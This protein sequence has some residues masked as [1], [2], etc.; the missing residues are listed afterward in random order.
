MIFP[1]IVPSV[2]FPHWYDKA[3]P[4][5][6][7]VSVNIAGSPLLQMVCVPATDPADTGKTGTLRVLL[8]LTHIRPF[9]ELVAILLN[10]VF[11][12]MPAPAL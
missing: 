9:K 11:C 1:N 8:A 7:L 12:V 5:A 6:G 2:D 10:H 4:A 3:G